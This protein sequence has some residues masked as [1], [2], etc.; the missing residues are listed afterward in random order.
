MFEVERG[1]FETPVLGMRPQKIKKGGSRGAVR[2]GRAGA[3]VDA[4]EVGGRERQSSLVAG[5][6]KKVTLR[7][8]TGVRT[9]LKKN[10]KASNAIGSFDDF[11]SH[12]TFCGVWLPRGVAE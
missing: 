11:E 3:P 6:E 7:L 2:A 12:S 1:K 8:E 9:G 4:R 10:P 5:E